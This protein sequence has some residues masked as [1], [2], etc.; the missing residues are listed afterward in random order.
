MF[1]SMDTYYLLPLPF[2][3]CSR[4]LRF[5]LLQLFCLIFIFFIFIILRRMGKNILLNIL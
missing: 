3:L 5:P 1:I 4:L 2:I